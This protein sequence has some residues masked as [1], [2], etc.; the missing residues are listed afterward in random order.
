MVA[1]DAM[2]GNG[3]ARRS[4]P[5][6]APLRPEAAAAG[7]RLCRDGV[8]L[9]TPGGEPVRLPTRE[10]AEA[11]ARE[12]AGGERLTAGDL[13][14]LVALALDRVRP[15]REAFLAGILAYGHADLLAYRA[16]S[17]PALVRRQAA[18]WD[19]LLAW[20][21]AELGAGL[22]TGAGVRPFRQ[23][24]A[25]MRALAAGMDAALAD[26]LL[27][28]LAAAAFA[29]LTTLTGSLVLALA[30]AH[31]R[32][33]AEA[34]WTLSRVDE[35]WQEEHWGVD[36]AAAAAAARRREAFLL[37]ARVLGSG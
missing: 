33:P 5:R 12:C 24:D 27:P 31:G 9:R 13:G 37:A 7:Y 17:P 26:R 21:A 16:E 8:P 35:R 30:V 19:P 10:L 20:A 3:R 1:A 2:A 25:A 15:G 34:A 4:L 29:E 22:R 14:R 6:L 36:A 28:E 32:L 18:V 11:L 23:D